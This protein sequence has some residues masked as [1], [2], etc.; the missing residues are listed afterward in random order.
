MNKIIITE[1]QLMEVVSDIDELNT[2]EKELYGYGMSHRVYPSK[3]NSDVLYKIGEIETV[4]KWVDVFKSNPKI[5]PVVYKVGDIKMPLKNFRGEVIKYYPARYVMIEKLDNKRAEN[6]F[7]LID[8][9]FDKH[10]P[11]GYDF[12][13]SIIDFED[14]GDTLSDMGE[15]MFKLDTNLF[16]VYIKFIKLILELHKIKKYPDLHIGQFGY[17]K[18]NN[19]KCLDF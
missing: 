10:H 5:F 9:F 18:K 1:S 2:R 16:N 12:H 13:M 15:L 8:K 3:K 17:D 7:K 6:D 11:D 14:E 4:R 19:L